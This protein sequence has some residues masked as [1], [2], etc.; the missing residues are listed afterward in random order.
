[1][2]I[3]RKEDSVRDF[4]VVEVREGP[5]AVGGIALL[6]KSAS[7]A[8]SSKMRKGMASYIPLICIDRRL[9]PNPGENNLVPH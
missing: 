4:V 7:T 8:F 5:V 3:S 1:M 9:A 6:F 2:R